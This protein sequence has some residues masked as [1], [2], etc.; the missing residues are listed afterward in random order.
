MNWKDIPDFEGLYQVSDCGQVKSC[1]R[2]VENSSTKSGKQTLKERILKP[3]LDK[4]GY[5]RVGLCK[6]GKMKDFYVHRLVALAFLD[7]DNSLTINHIDECKTNNHVSN[8]EYLTQGDNVRAWIKNN[9]ERR[10]EIDRKAQEASLKAR[11]Q[12]VLDT[13]TGETFP[14]IIAASRY[15]HEN[16]GAKGPWVWDGRIRLGTQDRFITLNN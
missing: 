14:S 7:G 15:M 10:A 12:K 2:V 16:E 1:E 8:L 5:H 9:P 4:D 6:D 13:Q 11:S 3:R